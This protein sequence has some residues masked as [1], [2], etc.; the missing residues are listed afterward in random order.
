ML[1][2]GSL[3]LDC[4]GG[5]SREDSWHAIKD[6]GKL[7]SIVPPADM[8]WVWNYDPPEGVSNT[9]VGKFL[10]MEPN[11]QHL[12]YIT[13]LIEQG[14]ARALVDSVHQL[15]DYHAAFDRMKSRRAVGKIILKVSDEA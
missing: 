8:I 5:K 14:K 13:Q 11:G 12:S 10:M 6:H 3:L 4:V 2:S 15:E 7:F 9:I 1:T